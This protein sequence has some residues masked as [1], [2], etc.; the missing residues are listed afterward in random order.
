MKK[1]IILSLIFLLWAVPIL[2]ANTHSIDLEKGSSQALTIADASQTGLDVS[3]DISIEAWIK[4][5]SINL[6]MGIV[7]KYDWGLASRSYAMEIATDNKIVFYVSDDG[8]STAGHLVGYKGA[9]ALGT[10]TWYHVAIT[11]DISAEEC[12]IYIDG[13][14]DSASQ[15]AGSSIGDTIYNGTGQLSIG[16]YSSN[17]G[18]EDSFDGL[19]DEARVWSDVRTP[20]EISDNYQTEIAGSEAGLV[21][22]WKVNDSLL[23][24]T[25]NDND[26]TNINTA[27]FS[28]D[29]PTWAA[30]D[31]CTCPTGDWYVNSSDNCYLSANCDLDEGGLYLLN[32]GEGAFNIIDNAILSITKL[33]STSTDINVENGCKILFK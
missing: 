2:A 3:T 11:F 9:T 1:Y 26:L 28:T 10:G 18:I 6:E 8:S 31:T 15:F 25:S 7:T 5:E 4:L 12:K 14:D 21:G 19:I 13:S 30:A 29:I 16:S 20:T 24:E 17:S 27:V 23:D 22:Y 33:E 32:T